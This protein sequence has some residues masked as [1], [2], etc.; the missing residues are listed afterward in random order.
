M[1]TLPLV[2]LVVKLPDFPAQDTEM[3]A[4]DWRLK[5]EDAVRPT[6][7][8]VPLCGAVKKSDHSVPERPF[9]EW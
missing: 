1:F 4:P 7:F 8:H 2:P 5:E 9:R 3:P 6:P